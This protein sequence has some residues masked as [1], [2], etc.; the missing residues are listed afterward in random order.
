[1]GTA[2][3]GDHEA[4]YDQLA[5]R[6]RQLSG[7]LREANLIAARMRA[8]VAQRQIFPAIAASISA[9]SGAGL[10]S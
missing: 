1:L 4:T 8:Y 10:R 2:G 7:H 6:N 3:E 9:S 5:T